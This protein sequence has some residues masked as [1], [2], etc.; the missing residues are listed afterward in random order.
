MTEKEKL[1]VDTTSKL[2]LNTLHDTFKSKTFKCSIYLLKYI[3]DKDVEYFDKF[4]NM[5]FKFN[6]VERMQVMYNVRT[7]L[8]AQ[9]KIKENQK[10][11]RIIEV[12]DKTSLRELGIPYIIFE[13]LDFNEQQKII[14]LNRKS[15]NN[16]KVDNYVTYDGTYFNANETPKKWHNKIEDKIDDAVYKKPVALVRKLVRRIKSR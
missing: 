4:I 10:P 14:H 16:N 11:S 6:M 12:I 15:K 13:Q 1:I 5:Y 9:G 2:V 7:N 3:Y 8:I